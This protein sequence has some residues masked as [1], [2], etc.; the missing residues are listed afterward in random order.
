MKPTIKILLNIKY[1][2]ILSGIIIGIIGGLGHS[3]YRATYFGEDLRLGQI[4]EAEAKL[5]RSMGYGGLIHNFKNFVLRGS[6]D[7][8]IAALRNHGEALQAVAELQILLPPRHEASLNNLRDVL[9]CYRDMIDRASQAMT[10]GASVGEIDRLVTIDN[11][12]VFD[13]I[14][15]IVVDVR[16]EIAAQQTERDREIR[17]FVR[18]LLILIVAILGFL[19]LLMREAARLRRENDRATG[20]A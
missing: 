7:Y 9:H 10:D 2:L 19:G 6:F 14:D 20:R 16:R 5:L 11:T 1:A 12:E 3:A 4:V 17:V 18:G 15:A 13:A 8:R